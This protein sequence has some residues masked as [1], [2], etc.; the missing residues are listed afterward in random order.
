VRRLRHRARTPL[1]TAKVFVPRELAE[2]PAVGAGKGSYALHRSG[3]AMPDHPASAECWLAHFSLRSPVQQ[4]LRVVTAELQK[5]G[6]AHAGRDVHYRLG[7]QLLAEDPDRFFA[8]V[9]QLPED[10]EWFPV[11]Y[12]GCPLRYVGKTTEPARLARALRPF[13]EQLARSLGDLSDLASPKSAVADSTD[14]IRPLDVATIPILEPDS[15]PFHG[16]TPLSGWQPEE[17]PFP[18]AFLPRFHRGTV[19]ESRFLLPPGLRRN[20]TLEIEAL[21]YAEGQI[22]TVLLNE[23]VVG[24]VRFPRVNEKESVRLPLALAAGENQLSLRY[25]ASMETPA[26]PRRLAMIFLALRVIPA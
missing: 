17:G 12:L 22:M 10:L 1:R 3:Q 18:E 15:P 4:V 11:C 23:T 20:A 21:S 5:L 13:L 25:Q 24:L 8:T 19:P 9:Y 7:F 26:D 14:Q 2:D 6:R 16:F